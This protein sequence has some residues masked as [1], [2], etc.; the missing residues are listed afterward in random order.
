VAV[1]STARILYSGFIHV[2]SQVA[3]FFWLKTTDKGRHRSISHF[4]TSDQN[5]SAEYEDSMKGAM[6]S[7]ELCITTSDTVETAV[8]YITSHT[9]QNI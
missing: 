5:I 1:Q 2:R 6:M 8:S 7:P 3:D 9:L 4:Y